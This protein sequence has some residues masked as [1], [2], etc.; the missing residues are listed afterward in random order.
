MFVILVVRYP[1]VFIY[2]AKIRNN[3][4]TEIDSLV[5]IV[6]NYLRRIGILQVACRCTC[7]EGF[8]NVAI[9]VRESS[10]NFYVNLS[11]VNKRFVALNIDN[12]IEIS[13]YF[14]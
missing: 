10:N 11:R 12:D 5:V 8:T 13:F 9:S 3:G 1:F 4:T 6:K 14:C 2:I 7:L